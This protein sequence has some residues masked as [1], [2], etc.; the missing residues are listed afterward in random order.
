MKRETLNYNFDPNGTAFV[1]LPGD[2]YAGDTFFDG[3]T[4][5]TDADPTHFVDGPTAKQKGYT[6]T[7]PNGTVI[8]KAD[9]TSTLPVGTFRE[10]VRIQSV[11]QYTTGLF[12]LDLNR[13]PWGC[14]I[15]PAFWTVGDNWPQNGEIDVLEGVHD[16]EHNQITWHTRPGCML[17]PNAT[18]SGTIATT[19]AGNH[20]N[21]DTSIDQNAGCAVTDWS[22][23]SYGPFFESQGGGVLAMKWDEN[24]I[25]VWS[26]FRAA[27]PQDILDGTPTPSAWGVPSATLLNSSS[28]DIPSYFQ[29]HRIVFD[30]TFCGQWAGAS[31][32]SSGCPGT[33]DQR[34][35]DPTN[36]V[37]AL[38][39]INSLK[40]Y[41]KVLVNGNLTGAAS[42]ILPE[43]TTGTHWWIIAAIIAAFYMLEGVLA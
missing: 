7:D 12:I 14:A 34:L 11:N 42:R 25:S 23:A 37:T 27:I 28:C 30:I 29:S 4:F 26:F 13:A 38:W 1:W 32:A 33:C 10:S 17:N 16:N 21:C 35:T 19:A 36:F 9:D 24:D 40:V 5:F 41:N 22:R 15:W 39:S 18:F 6:F 31:Y 43:R 3:F 2:N 8:M 20:T